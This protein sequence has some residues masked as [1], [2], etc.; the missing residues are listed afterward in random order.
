MARAGCA[1][2]RG[3]ERAG[4]VRRWLHAAPVAVFLA[5]AVALGLGLGR[6]PGL[7]P[8]AL[9]GAPAPQTRLPAVEGYGPA[10]SNEDFLG[11]ITLVNVF[12]SWC[13]SCILEHPLLMR[14][15][16]MPGIAVVGLAYKDDPAD[17]ARWLARHGNPYAATAADTTGRAGIDWG[18]YGVPETFLVGPDGVVVFKQVGPL[19]AE[20]WRDGFLPAIEALRS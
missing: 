1:G 12:A 16:E 5:L 10:F 18:V 13:A 11:R 7:V 9:I 6:D 20:I 15:S 2:E 8:S 3:K 17:T 14:I 19:D 4:G